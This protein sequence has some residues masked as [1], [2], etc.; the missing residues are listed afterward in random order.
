MAL[1]LP[2]ELWQLIGSGE[3][4]VITFNCVLN[5]EAVNS[6][7]P[8]THRQ[9]WLESKNH[10]PKQKSI[11]VGSGSLE[12]GG[13]AEVGLGVKEDGGVRISTV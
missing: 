10:K 4:T 1:P 3:G 11:N 13:V 9:P 7:K 6:S 8:M 5:G 2:D 12:M